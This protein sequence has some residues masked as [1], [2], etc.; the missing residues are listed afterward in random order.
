MARVAGA[1]FDR[2]EQ[3]DSEDAKIYSDIAHFRDGLKHAWC[4]TQWQVME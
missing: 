3:C 4:A 2:I 1:L